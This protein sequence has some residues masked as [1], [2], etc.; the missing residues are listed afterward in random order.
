MNN[1]GDI[2]SNARILLNDPYSGVWENSELLTYGNE[3]IGDVAKSS[4]Y[5]EDYRDYALESGTALYDRDSDA[6]YIERVEYNGSAVPMMEFS[7]ISEGNPNWQ[8]ETGEVS[9][10]FSFGTNHIIYYPIPVWTADLSTFDSEYGLIIDA[11]YTG[12][13]ITF[14]S[15]YGILIDCDTDMEDTIYFTDDPAYG[16]VVMVDEAADAINLRV[17]ISPAA[18]VNNT[19]IPDMPQWFFRM[20]VFYICWRALNRDSPARDKKLAKFYKGMYDDCLKTFMSFYCKGHKPKAQFTG[21]KPMTRT[22]K[23]RYYIG[24]R[25]DV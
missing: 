8:Y 25:Y 20:I 19:D 14:D 15:E 13:T 23:E 12:V 10:W 2:L 17:V 11:T 1:T 18:L 4:R 9:A 16:E 5:L 24:G 7:E 21:M 3:C 22:S 6:I